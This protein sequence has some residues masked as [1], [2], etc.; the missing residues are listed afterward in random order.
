V[1]I[2]DEIVVGLMAA[3]CGIDFAEATATGVDKFMVSGVEIPVARKPLLI[4]MKE[5]VR[6]SDA[7]DVRFL[8][9]KIEE[10]GR[11]S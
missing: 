8:R 1:R 3:A 6:E 10:E 2:A 7:V 5:T 9:L 4:R 11:R